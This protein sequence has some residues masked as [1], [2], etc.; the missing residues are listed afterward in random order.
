[1]LVDNNVTRRSQFRLAP[2]WQ[3][4]IAAVLALCLSSIG[5]TPAVALSVDDYF[6][7]SYST[8]LSKDQVQEGEVFYATVIGQATCINNL[9]FGLSPSTATVTGRVVAEH[10][11]SGAQVI[12]NPSYSVSI[13]SFPGKGETVQESKTVSLQ[14]PGG[15]QAGTYQV[16]GEI[17]EARV[18]ALIWF[19]VTAELPQS[20][21]LGSVTYISA[22]SN[23]GSTGVPP[24]PE[25]L[26]TKTIFTTGRIDNQGIINR[27]F[28]APSWDNKCTVTLGT[29]TKALDKNSRP[30][31]AITLVNTLEPH[32]FPANHSSVSLIY[33]LGPV[34]ATFDP[35][36]IL[37]MT[38]NES[39]IPEG[40]T[41]D[42]LAIARWDEVSSQ[43][44]K[45]ESCVVD[46]VTNTI[47]APISHFS[48]YTVL[49]PLR[50]ASFT[51]TELT[52]SPPEVVTGEKLE[53]TTIVANTGN[54]EGSYQ[55]TLKINN[56]VEEVR[57]IV[58]AGNSSE[59]VTFDISRDIANSYS[60]DVNGLSGS[61]VVTEKTP[62]GDPA[63]F[64]IRDLTISQDE[65][66]RG[67]K[68]GITVL[69]AN[70]GD[71]EGSYQLTLTINNEEVEGREITLPG[72]A[73]ETIIFDISPDIAGNY[74]VNVN[75]LLDSFTVKDKSTPTP[76]YTQTPAPINSSVEPTNWWL[77]GS[78]CTI[79]I[80]LLIIIVQLIRRRRTG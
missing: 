74:S 18:K 76:A 51:I 22:G 65:V 8:T 69:V 70:N 50:E 21:S 28:T 46:S 6:V 71:L 62:T 33:D 15:S 9:P 54:L 42:S 72:S 7:V 41:E 48:I 37:T 67:E 14:F 79:N 19:D 5:I 56:Q 78:I 38:Y 80:V 75:G 24:I 30:L 43:W 57:E 36:I 39:S 45:L 23:G 3:W 27:T 55:V 26:L 77:I 11:Q 35:P 25:Q 32:P 52:L 34:G 4:V 13:S 66:Y 40:G 58:L 12:L 53:V 2:V 47:T 61:F 1:M 44:L 60:V 68:I 64:T 49:A 20:E 29:G 17:I 10:S 59:K 63:T 73:T 31:I 16:T